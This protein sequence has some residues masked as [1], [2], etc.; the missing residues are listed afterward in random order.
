MA[1]AARR[2][3]R[4]DVGIGITGVAGP[5]EQEGKAVGTVFVSISLNQKV[6]SLA[7]RLPPRRAVVKFR[8]ANTALVEL[9]RLLNEG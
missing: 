7:L 1:H 2:G 8:A 9:Q 5:A 6:K 3:L 4:A